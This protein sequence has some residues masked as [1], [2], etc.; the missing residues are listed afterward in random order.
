MSRGENHICNNAKH[1]DGNIQTEPWQPRRGSIKFNELE[2]RE[3]IGVQKVNKDQGGKVCKEMRCL[4][5][6][7]KEVS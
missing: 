3:G 7:L 6:V 1:R 2:E 4:S 5:W